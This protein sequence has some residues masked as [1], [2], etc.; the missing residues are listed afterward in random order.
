[1]WRN[2]V[3]HSLW[4]RGVASSSLAIPTINLYKGSHIMNKK[5]I[6]LLSFS[7]SLPVYVKTVPSEPV[8]TSPTCNHDTQQLT[9]T[10]LQW[11]ATYQSLDSFSLQL[12]GNFL[13]F[14][15]KQALLNTRLYRK[16]DTL[17]RVLKKTVHTVEAYGNPSGATTLLYY[18]VHQFQ[19]TARARYNAYMSWTHCNRYLEDQGN[20]TVRQA[21]A[22]LQEQGT[23]WVAGSLRDQQKLHEKTQELFFAYYKALYRYLAQRDEQYQMI[24]FSP[25][26]F[27][28][29]GE[30]V[31]HLEP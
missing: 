20:E 24:L 19:A 16:T 15:Y 8:N 1:M 7:I 4:E 23:R 26:G 13:Y 25:R 5:L 28:T 3:A 27:L 31:T 2:W 17:I 14:S 22:H 6:L 18:T 29:K 10:A 30:Q 12:L 21:L 11:A 9:Q